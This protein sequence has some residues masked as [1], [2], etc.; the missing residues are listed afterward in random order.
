VG[1]RKNSSADFDQCLQNGKSTNLQET[2]DINS[3]S[4]SY[5][6]MKEKMLCFY[7]GQTF[8]DEDEKPLTE[9]ITA[10]ITTNLGKKVKIIYIFIIFQSCFRFLI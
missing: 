1:T 5:S 10:N 9:N 3:I 7:S 8:T 2:E 4:I 6:N